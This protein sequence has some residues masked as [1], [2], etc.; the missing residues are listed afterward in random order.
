MIMRGFRDYRGLHS[1]ISGPAESL[2]IFV[3]QFVHFID[4][5]AEIGMAWVHWRQFPSPAAG[6]TTSGAT[7]AAAAS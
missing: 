7:A 1:I 6:G 5:F 3:H 2:W 4:S